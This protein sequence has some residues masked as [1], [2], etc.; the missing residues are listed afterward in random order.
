VCE[1]ERSKSGGNLAE[2]MLTGEEIRNVEDRKEKF[3]LEERQR[4][5]KA[6]TKVLALLDKSTNTDT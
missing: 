1:R 3:K 2:N 5:T 6:G 4:A